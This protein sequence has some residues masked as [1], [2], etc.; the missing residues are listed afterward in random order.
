[1]IVL[2]HS[3]PVPILTVHEPRSGPEKEVD[4]DMSQNVEEDLVPFVGPTRYWTARGG[5]GGV[6]R[7][8]GK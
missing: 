8:S 1:M 6:A 5:E 2:H 3:L 7:T 4:S